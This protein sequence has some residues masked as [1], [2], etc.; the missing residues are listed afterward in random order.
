MLK[1]TPSR[2]AAVQDVAVH[3]LQMDVGDALGMRAHDGD[4]IDAAVDRMAHIPAQFDQRRGR[5]AQKLLQVLE[6]FDPRARVQVKGRLQ[7]VLA[8][9]L[10]RPADALRQLIPLSRAE[11]GRVGGAGAAGEGLSLGRALIGQVG[12]R[13]ANLG[14]EPAQATRVF[15]VGLEVGL[16]EPESAP[17]GRQRQ[18]A[19]LERVPQRLWIAREPVAKLRR[20]V[21]RPATS[22]STV[23]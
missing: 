12:E 7:A 15:Q 13:G 1:S 2:R 10:G 6:R 19:T 22:S 16:K 9:D 5:A 14:Q 23:V 20:R 8:D 11:V 17:G 3:V 21:T 4:G 18:P